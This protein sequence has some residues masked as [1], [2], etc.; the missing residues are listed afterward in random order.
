MNRQMKR[1]QERQERQNKRSGVDRQAAPAA[2]TRRAA[3][4]EKRERTSVREFLRQ[5]RQELS[6]VDWP[7]RRELASYTVVV[8]VT[9]VVMTAFVFALDLGFSKVIV[10]FLT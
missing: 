9:V 4:R 1:A 6:K 7:T 5:V 10:N 8:L 3:V 2:V